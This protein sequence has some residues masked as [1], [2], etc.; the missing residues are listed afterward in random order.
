MICTVGDQLRGH[1]LCEALELGPYVFR[2]RVLLG[3]RGDAPLV[4]GDAVLLE[5]GDETLIGLTEVQRALRLRPKSKHELGWFRPSR[6]S[7]LQ[8]WKLWLELSQLIVGESLAEPD[9]VGQPESGQRPELRGAHD[10]P[11]WRIGVLG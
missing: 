8:G 7:L 2:R 11:D 5:L 3:I 4:D 10:L 6:R 9:D 1:A